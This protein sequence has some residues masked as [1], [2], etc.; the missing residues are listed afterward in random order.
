MKRP[1]PREFDTGSDSLNVTKKKMRGL[2]CLL[3]LLMSA[4][5]SFAQVRLSIDMTKAT[6]PEVFKEITRQTGY[7]FMY[8]GNELPSGT[9][10]VKAADMDLGEVLSLC[11]K[12]TKLGYLIDNKVIVI[13]PKIGTSNGQPVVKGVVRNQAGAPIQAV[14][15]TVPGTNIGVLTD[16]NGAFQLP[17]QQGMKL[18]FS[19]VGMM[20]REVEVKDIHSRETLDIVLYE[21]VKEIEDIVVTGYGNIKKST[22]TGTV[23]SVTKDDLL[24]VSPGNLIQS[25][26]VFDPGLRIAAN[27]LA[28]SNP[29]AMP[30]L[31]IRGRSGLDGVRTLDKLDDI[32]KY[33]LV[34]NP[35]LPIFVLDGFEVSVEKVY[36]LDLNTVKSINILKDAAATAMYGSRAANGVIVIETA[37]PAM[38]KLR[39]S[40]NFS[41][42]Y[43]TPDLTDY[44]LMN[45][46]QKLEA[47]LAAGLLDPEDPALPGNA[48]F[49]FRQEHYYLVAS[50][51]KRGVDTY[52]LSQPLQSAYSAKNTVR[53]EGGDD[54]VRFSLGAKYETNNG[55]MK[56]SYRNNFGVDMK[57]TYR[58]KGLN[59]SNAVYYDRMEK[60]ES[61]YGTFGEYVK[62]QPYYSPWDLT[63]G[64]LLTRMPTNWFNNPGVVNPLYEASLGHFNRG[65]Y[66]DFTDNLLVNWSFLRD[67]QLRAQF[68]VNYKETDNDRFTDPKSTQYDI[69]NTTLFQ[70]GD[71]YRE[72]WSSFGWNTNLL[73]LYSKTAGEQYVSGQFVFNAKNDVSEYNYAHYRGFTDSELNTQQYAREIVGKPAL[74]DDHTRLLGAMLAANYSFRDIY[75]ADFSLR[76]DGSSQFGANKKYAPFW[77]VGAGINIHNYG[78]L[79]D[80][81]TVSMLRLKGN[82]GQTG[83]VEYPPFAA[84]HTYSLLMDE[85]HTT[86]IGAILAYMGNV[87]LGWAKTDEAS[88]GIDAKLFGEL[89]YLELAYYDKMT[90]N[91]ITDITIPSSSGFTVYK[92]NVGQVQNRGYEVKLAVTP[93]QN[94]NWGVRVFANVAHN[95]NQIKKISNALK[96]Y[97][98]RVDEYYGRYS[99]WMGIGYN[100]EYAKPLLKYVEG[101]SLTSIFGMQSLG[102][103]PANGK[104]LYLNRDGT[105][106]Y[107]WDPA[108]QQIIGNTEPKLS[109]SLGCNLRYKQFTLFAS[110]LFETGGQAYNQTLVDYVENLNL[111][112][113]NGDVRV[114]TD[115]WQK[116][117]DIAPLKSIQDRYRVTRPTSRFMQDNDYLSFNSLSIMYDFDRSLLRKVG[118]GMANLAFYMEDVARISSIK[119]ERGI[120]YPYARSFRLALNVTF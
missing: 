110:F 25:L 51:V 97:N 50:N 14:S 95:K 2:S 13:S 112:A 58:Y 61:P 111:W 64:E 47:E 56:D 113:R 119:I 21:D 74:Q 22:F 99:N 33:A 79:K 5:V 29:N 31:Y 43:T 82:Y 55:V 62:M 70:R 67:F 52:W 7:E 40:Y 101:G 53:I 120:D 15:V 78:F 24:K 102:I 20:H 48:S 16:R 96:A 68:S 18:A 12:N 87:D 80:S 105:V 23:T 71:L 10:N 76:L 32:S 72:N 91:L 8:S 30:E 39:V 98:D 41:G 3:L 11:L 59:I 106:S 107:T 114:F 1:E 63:T 93:L 69:Y 89:L 116:P 117:G 46:S 17:A 94:K 4:T 35:N 27:D 86:G 26:Q 42:T 104:E 83:K 57:A 108:Q 77:S 38:G 84:R 109:G 73:L 49:P 100:T 115:R 75:L 44:H 66:N 34:K 90:N 9:V 36:D 19:Y 45:S 65:G 6:L 81:K 85:W 60:Q 118:V 54:L 92:E 103:S 88:V 37:P 28:G